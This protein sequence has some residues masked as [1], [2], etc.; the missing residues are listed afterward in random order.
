MIVDTHAHLQT[1]EFAEDWPAVVERARA[2]D[3]RVIVTVGTGV[4]SSQAA[5]ELANREEGI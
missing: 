5:L 1:K 3:V 2:A 4:E